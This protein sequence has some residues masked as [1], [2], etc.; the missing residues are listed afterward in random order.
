VNRRLIGL[1]IAV[2]LAGV[3]TFLLVQWVTTADER[4]R[5]DEELV[6]VF[7]AQGDLSPGTSASDAIAQ[8]LI[9]TDAIPARAVPQGAIGDL[10]QISGLIVATPVYAGE[11]LVAQRFGRTVAQPDGLL[12][13]P[14]GLE[15][16]TVEA[17]IVD[18]LAGFVEPGATVSVVA[19]LTVPGD[20]P[21]VDP[22]DPDAEAEAVPAGIRTQ[23]LVQHATVLAVGQRVVTTE[24][25]QETTGIRRSNE[26][27]IF[28]L[29]MVP[30]DIEQ[31]VFA[32][33]QG[34]LWFTLLPELEEGEE[35][36][37]FDTAGRTIEDIFE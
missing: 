32:H 12:E 10:E 19:T 5:V 20:E 17:G 18:G 2:V 9:D 16:V 29:G 15:G 7:V 36:E 24:E 13:V 11:V 4:A 34:Q 25:G 27:Y 28:T 1:I 22:E 21:A 31:L 30:E 6:E 14:E 23:Y 26:R 33:Q 3:A 8:G 37:D 35:Y